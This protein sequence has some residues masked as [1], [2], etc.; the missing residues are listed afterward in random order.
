[1]YSSI[2]IP[3]SLFIM[4]LQTSQAVDIMCAA[5]LTVPYVKE[6]CKHHFPDFGEQMAI[7]GDGDCSHCG[8]NCGQAPPGL[9]LKRHTHQAVH[10]NC[11]G[12][13]GNDCYYDLDCKSASYPT[14]SAHVIDTENL[15]YLYYDEDL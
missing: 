10:R 14:A 9:K 1:M 12:N 7:G 4:Y 13:A 15:I 6:A 2:I 3:L 11:N 8:A 5:K